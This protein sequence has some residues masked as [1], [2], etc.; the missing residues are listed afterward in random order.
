M[1]SS[2]SRSEGEAGW[3]VYENGLFYAL[4]EPP[5]CPRVVGCSELV[6]PPPSLTQPP[7]L[8]GGGG[9]RGGGEPLRSNRY[10][11]C[12]EQTPLPPGRQKFP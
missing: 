9:L 4:V 8:C 6:E 1:V 7:P 11:S 3:G 5:P 12:G 2:P 10:E